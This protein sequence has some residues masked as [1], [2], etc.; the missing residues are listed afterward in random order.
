M[1]K[2]L[3]G[4]HILFARNVKDVTSTFPTPI[5]SALTLFL[6]PSSIT[7]RAGT[8]DFLLFHWH[9]QCPMRDVHMRAGS[10][11][12]RFSAYIWS[13]QTFLLFIR[14]TWPA[15]LFFLWIFTGS[16]AF[17]NQWWLHQQYSETNIELDV[18]AKRSR[19]YVF[20]CTAKN[21][22][23]FFCGHK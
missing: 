7:Q 15:I 14:E 9:W 22:E 6:F 20:S 12:P 18:V 13:T 10:D 1:R 2:L 19:E 16:V 11:F 21:I 4:S 5:L 23:F 17:E 8:M 3:L